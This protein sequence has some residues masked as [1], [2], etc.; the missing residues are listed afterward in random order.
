MSWWKGLRA[1]LS[2]SDQET[3]VSDRRGDQEVL[4]SQGCVPPGTP[5]SDEALLPR[6]HHSS[7]Q[8][9]NLLW[10]KPFSVPEPS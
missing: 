10:V 9:L 2:L 8:S 5:F 3:G 6:S 7:I 4:T 1:E